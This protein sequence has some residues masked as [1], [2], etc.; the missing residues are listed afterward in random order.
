MSGVDTASIK[1]TADLI[2]HDFVPGVPK[3]YQCPLV[4]AE[5]G[6]G[7][8]RAGGDD[9]LG[10]LP[11]GYSVKVGG[12]CRT[13]SYRGLYLSP[14]QGWHVL[15]REGLHDGCLRDRAVSYWTNLA[16]TELEDVSPASALQTSKASI[17]PPSWSTA[18]I[19]IVDAVARGVAPARIEISRFDDR[20]QVQ[21]MPVTN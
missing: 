16:E 7:S 11:P 2:S 15:S 5:D 14:G 10:R 21:K 18:S 12:S 3:G 6:G 19:T 8:T 4:A 20:V 13:A 17:I 9:V 1:P